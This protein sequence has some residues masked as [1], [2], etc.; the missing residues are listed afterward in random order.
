MKCLVNPSHTTNL[1]VK[2]HDPILILKFIMTEPLTPMSCPFV[3]LMHV[4][5]SEIW[6]NNPSADTVSYL[7]QLTCAPVSNSEENTELFT[8]I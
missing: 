4:L 2:L 5:L 3:V 6:C 1:C 8:F 7:M